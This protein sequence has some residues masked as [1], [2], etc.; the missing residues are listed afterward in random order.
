[1][2]KR[3]NSLILDY[4][5][6]VWVISSLSFVRFYVY[7][8][9][10]LGYRNRMIA[11][12]NK[13]RFGTPKIIFQVTTKGG[14][15]I[16]Q[17]TI[18]QIQEVC[19][20]IEY[21]KYEVWVVTDA[22][23][24]FRNCRTIIVPREYSCNAVFKGRALQYVVELRSTEKKNTNDIYV[25]HLDDESVVTEQTVCSILT[26]LENKPAPITE[27]LILYPLHENE[28]IKISNMLDTIRPFC[29]FECME[30]MKKGNPAYM[31]GSNLLVRSDVEEKVG[32]DNGKTFAEDSLF[33]IAARKKLGS[34]AFGWHGAVVEE[35]S[36]RNL[37]DVI[38][39]RKRW[40]YG[41]VQNLKYLTFRDKMLQVTRALIWSSGFISGLVS[42]FALLIPQ[43][44]P[45]VLRVFFLMASLLWLLSYQIG[46]FLNSRHL[47]RSKR[48]TFHLLTLASTPL[49][50]I[51]ECS[52][53][54][55]SVIRRPGTF[56]VIEK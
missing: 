55:L 50:G 36:P 28:I 47:S 33:A 13:T 1:M 34:A 5:W 19:Q 43:D 15:P 37:R 26:Y 23:E 16:V 42:I 56:E 18:D 12:P 32:W 38:R 11:K 10:A 53:P 24:E 54:M 44:I 48:L 29:C 14:I 39:Q 22:E 9:R 31:H 46:A 35:K 8:A 17:K 52:I 3:L 7:V 41:L 27:G 20:K 30:F 21:T 49:I 4:L 25:F 45:A 40:F 51:I 6:L 2:S